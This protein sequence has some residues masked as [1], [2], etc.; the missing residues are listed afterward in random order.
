MK[1]QQERLAICQLCD[2][3]TTQ[4]WVDEANEFGC[5]I[6]YNAYGVEFMEF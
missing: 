4:V 3:Y 2:N 5:E 6:C 1:I